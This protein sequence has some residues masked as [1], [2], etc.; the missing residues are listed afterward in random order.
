M[1]L[2]DSQLTAYLHGRRDEQD[3]TVAVLEQMK[4][5]GYV[6]LDVFTIMID[7]LARVDRRPKP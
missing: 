7:Y 1:T 5:L 4:E 6:S 2:S 3:D